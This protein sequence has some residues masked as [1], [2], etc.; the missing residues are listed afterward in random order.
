MT[1]LDRILILGLTAT[2]VSALPAAVVLAPVHA[3]CKVHPEQ[4]ARCAAAGTSLDN[5]HSN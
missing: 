4:Q 2:M 3:D 1:R 5:D